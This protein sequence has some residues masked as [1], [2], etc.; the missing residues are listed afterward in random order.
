MRH[1]RYTLAMIACS[2]LFGG[3]ATHKMSGDQL[4]RVAKDWSLSIRASQVIPVY[5]LTED[6]QPGD[7][8]LVQTPIED[9]VKV[10]LDKGFLPLENLVT[11][12][13]LT[14]YRDFYPKW[15]LIDADNSPAP[16]RAWQFPLDKTDPDFSGAPIAAFPTYSFSVSRSEGLSVAVPVQ[17][18]PVGLNLLDSASAN[19]TITLKD[20]YTYGLPITVT[21]YE[22]TQWAASHAEYLS[23]FAPQPQSADDKAPK[24]EY[25]LRVINRV[26]L[27]KTVDVAL[28]SNAGFGL[29]AS[30]GVPQGIQLLNLG[31]GNEAAKQFDAINS[32]LAKASS[33]KADEVPKPTGGV[34]PAADTITGPP[35]IAAG[36]SLR[37]AMA[38]ARSISLVETFRRPLAIGYLATDYKILG[39]GQLAVPVPTVLHLEGRI[40]TGEKALVY[41]GCDANCKVLRVW[42]RASENKKAL[43]GW[44]QAHANSVSISNFLTTAPYGSLRATA[45]TELVKPTE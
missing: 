39:G 16:P 41:Q 5:P 19:G 1:V 10:Y 6:L 4:A 7:V 28:F 18:V 2:M 30:A 15:P 29:G 23:Q 32:I 35:P 34:T 25:Y 44:L 26:Y 27:V 33:S 9:Q 3:C 31:N 37:V 36:G 40:K 11:R 38:T 21:Y 13:P 45:V 17:A 22:V 20:A 24:R 14:G 12:L 43:E 42:V 8:F